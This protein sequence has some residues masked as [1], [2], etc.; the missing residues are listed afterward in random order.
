M[1]FL[2]KNF[3]SWQVLYVGRTVL[4]G[5]FPSKVQILTG[6]EELFGMVL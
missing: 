6:S 3:I 5:S 4:S 1:S 2:T